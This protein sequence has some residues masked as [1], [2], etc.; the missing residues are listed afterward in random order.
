M[1]SE[2]NNFKAKPLERLSIVQTEEDRNLSK[3]HLSTDGYLI[4]AN[5]GFESIDFE[6]IIK[7]TATI[8]AGGEIEE[9]KDNN[10][11]LIKPSKCPFCHQANFIE[12]SLLNHDLYGQQ[13]C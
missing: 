8:A 10:V 12:V 13:I 7:T 6:V 2:Y 5:C 11:M 3:A 4:C 9:I 1:A